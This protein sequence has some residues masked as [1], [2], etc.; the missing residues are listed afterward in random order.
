MESTGA[1]SV[2]AVATTTT[3]A[4]AAPVATQRRNRFS[5]SVQPAGEK[6]VCVVCNQPFPAR[7]CDQCGDKYCDGCYSM[8]HQA[9]RKAKHTF[10][11]INGADA[12]AGAVG[13][14]VG[15][16]WVQYVDEASGVPYYYNNATGAS[17]WEAP[18]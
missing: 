8:S 14:A 16:D 7:M 1:A 4:R 6:N 15:G 2:T 17:Q 12:H 5:N 11:A 10:T 13:I 9:G 18:I 3:T